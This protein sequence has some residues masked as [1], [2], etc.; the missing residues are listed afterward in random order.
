MDREIEL[1]SVSSSKDANPMRSEPHLYD[2]IL[3]LIT[4]LGGPS[5][6]KVILEFRAST[7]ELGLG[8]YKHSLCKT[9][10]VRIQIQTCPVPKLIF[11]IAELY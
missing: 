10:R 3:T 8:E 7:Y 6:N 9:D 2:L 5:P 11:L 4:S 1:S